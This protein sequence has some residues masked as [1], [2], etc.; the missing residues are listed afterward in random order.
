M[1]VPL[2]HACTRTPVTALAFAGQY[3]LTAEGPFLRVFLKSGSDCLF[4]EKIFENQTVHGLAVVDA[5]HSDYLSVIAY[6]GHLV[7]HLRLSHDG[8]ARTF[9]LDQGPVA[10]VS[11]W[12]LDLAHPFQ[13]L[14]TTVAVTAHNQIV[15]LC[16]TSSPPSACL[17]VSNLTVSSR[18][19]LYSAHLSWL[20]AAKVLVASGTAF[21]EILVWSCDF[22]NLDKPRSCVH[23]FFTGHEGSVFGVQISLPFYV[24]EDQTNRHQLLASC[25]DDRT[26]RIWDISQLP[27]GGDFSTSDDALGLVQDRETGFGAN[28]NS[29]QENCLAVAWGH[30]SRVWAIRF[31]AFS[32]ADKARRFVSFGED[33]TTRVWDLNCTLSA[34]D[35]S[36]RLKVDATL[37]DTRAFHSGKNIWA[38]DIATPTQPADFEIC[39]GAA[40]SAIVSHHWPLTPLESVSPQPTTDAHRCCS[41]VSDRVVISATN[42]G[43]VIRGSDSNNAFA[44][45]VVDQIDDLKGYSVSVG[46]PV[47]NLAFLAGSSGKIYAYQDSS[48]QFSVVAQMSRKIATIFASHFCDLDGA[49]FISLI[50]TTVGAK[51]TE[52]FLF[53][54]EPDSV[55]LVLK[56]KTTLDLPRSFVVTSALYT[57]MLVQTIIFLG[58]RNGSVAQ[59]SD[60]AR[61]EASEVET[62]QP[63][64]VFELHAP[65]TVTAL[66]WIPH[67]SSTLTQ[68]H[69]LGYLIST[70]RDGHY[71][72]T[73]IS[74]DM[75]AIVA[76]QISLPFGPNIEGC[77]VD[78]GSLV[79]YGFRGK[80]F[81][82]IDASTEQEVFSVEC[83]G[84]HRIWS[85]CPSD[86]SEGGTFV[87]NQASTLKLHSTSGVSHKIIRSGGHGREIKNAAACPS[88][89]RMV[90]TGAEDTTIR[91]FE[92]GVHDSSLPDFR[93]VRVLRKHVTGIQH[94]AWSDDGKYLFSSGGYEEFFVWRVR[95]LP[96]VGL[97]IVC[98]AVC[99]PESE[100]PDL[101]I[102]GFS[103]QASPKAGADASFLAT[104]A[105]SDSTIR[106]YSYIST[107][108]AKT[109]TLLHAGTY[110]TSCLTQT[111]YLT[112]SLLLTA[113]TDGHIA[114][115]P[116]PPTNNNNTNASDASASDSTSPPLPLTPTSRTPIHQSTIK[117]LAHTRLSPTTSLLLTAGDDNAVAFTLLLLR[118]DDSAA[119]ADA[120][121]GGGGGPDGA[122]SAGNDA[123]RTSTLV[124]PRAHA[125]TV[126]S[127]VLLC[128]GDDGG[129]GGGGD[130]D[131]KRSD[132]DA[133]AD[134]TAPT[135]STT[136]TTTSTTPKTTTTQMKRLL[137]ITAGSD[138]RV[139]VWEVG[140]DVDDGVGVG[141]EAVRVRRLADEGTAVADV[142]DVVVLAGGGGGGGAGGDGD[143]VGELLPPG[144][145][146]RRTTGR[147]RTVVV[148]G[149]GM[150]AW[151]V[152]VGGL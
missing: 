108:T 19:I 118:A 129:G 96:V 113:G 16:W 8:I 126:T 31:I 95:Q 81:V 58:A 35:R 83:G 144:R 100:L 50:V 75:H 105:Y 89:P 46:L 147:T 120:D 99:P 122:G 63:C 54:W 117:A 107:P 57:P 34:H 65:E 61:E 27:D 3:I 125:A 73:E 37:L 140:V 76:H 101:R 66:A 74:T 110:L 91:I 93:C 88:N 72:T 26:V 79:V 132:A 44:W 139:K 43:K 56:K 87:W 22:T 51:V 149:V 103:I 109:F 71:A 67:E 29:D 112:P 150:E 60:T 137:A 114:F 13:K 38:M 84:A 14:N 80:H 2:H 6:G 152:E 102:M 7:R 94:L 134:A 131:G 49:G 135:T 69:L 39:T 20:S 17:T 138:Q 124:I 92:Y 48:R 146:V 98:E 104:L 77:F 116:L 68:N 128:A 130:D 119:A 36:P 25:S 62:L 136:T 127:A 15:R 86:A 97:G 11:D 52:S 32:P 82:A 78:R 142:A 45:E 70:G 143:G 121:A 4:T 148:V 30:T 33:A 12:V 133:D 9:G 111:T 18:C 115:W 151:E 21:G 106:T 10:R 145:R 28:A 1:S 55:G 47:C 90:A 59:F 42:S 53:S 85:F 40:D 23:H 41:F 123:V 141:A 64:A 24:S 5:S